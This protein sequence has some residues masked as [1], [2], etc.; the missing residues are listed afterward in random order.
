MNITLID[1]YHLK[2]NTT[3]ESSTAVIA[4]RLDLAYLVPGVI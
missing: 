2:F 1:N 3:D 4:A